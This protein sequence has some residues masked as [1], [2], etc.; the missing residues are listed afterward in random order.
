VLVATVITSVISATPEVADAGD[1]KVSIAVF[2]ASPDAEVGKARRATLLLTMEEALHEDTRLDV[3]DKDTQLAEGAGFVPKEVISEARG[4]LG[5][6]EAMLL[7]GRAKAALTRLKTAETQLSAALAY[8]SKREVARAQFLVGAAQAIL[9]KT[10]SARKTFM[11]L[12]VWRPDFVADTSIEPALVMPVWEEAVARV[13]KL[14][15]GSIE[16]TSKPS[17]ALAYVDG[18]FI[19]FTPTTA[20][21]LVVGEHYVTFKAVGYAR[22]VKR[23]T[24]SSDEQNAVSTKLVRSPS[25]DAVDEL[26]AELLPSLGSS[27]G[28]KALEKLAPLLGI[29]HAVF[30]LVPPPGEKGEYQAYVYDTKTRKRLSAARAPASAEVETTFSEMAVSLYASLILEPIEE[31]VVEEEPDRDDRGSPF[32]KKWWF[33]AAVG[34]VATTAITVPLVIGGGTDAPTCPPGSVCGE[35][36]WDF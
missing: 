2:I 34:A 21:G 24:V 13:A 30:V 23:V 18:T 31:E 14:D 17:G 5:S 19:G 3:I 32:Y 25:S 8:V 16:V 20:E 22:E 9:G 15:G 12:Q 35:V 36:I 7:K 10:K 27:T 28:P 33:W 26:V 1:D 4:L 11:R 6:G 29:Q